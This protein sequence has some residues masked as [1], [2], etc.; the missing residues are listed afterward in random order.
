[1]KAEPS[2]ND[3]TKSAE[4]GLTPR[5][6]APV[7][8]PSPAVA[9]SNQPATES[10]SPKPAAASEEQ[11]PASAAEASKVE[12]SASAPTNE[13]AVQPVAQ[14]SPP[15]AAQAL[16]VVQQPVSLPV[17]ETVAVQIPHDSLRGTDASPT[18][19]VDASNGIVPLPASKPA[20]AI[21]APADKK[22]PIAIFISRK[23]QR[24]Y[25][26]Q[27]FEPMFDAAI[28]ID[29][30]EQPIGT[31]VFTAMAYLN[32]GS[33]FRWDVI[34]MPGVQPK[35]KRVQSKESSATTGTA[36][37]GGKT[38]PKNRQAT[39]RR[40]RHRQRRWPASRFRRTLSTGFRR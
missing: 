35:A 4:A 22:T 40:R 11:K 12:V 5:P 3:G 39:P 2:G 9:G 7:T 32:D 30:P 21:Q 14:T 1:M 10:D 18:L 23:T 25:V 31:H 34:S 27:N 17:K 19:L 26:R 8:D 29:H 36:K 33:T 13:T 38:L 15:P 6:E 28:S 20:D 37:A 24:I 16:P